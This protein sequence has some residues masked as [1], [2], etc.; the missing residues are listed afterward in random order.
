MLD[1]Q[2]K[3]SLQVICDLREIQADINNDEKLQTLWQEVSPRLVGKVLE[4]GKPLAISVSQGK[5]SLWSLDAQK[6]PPIAEN[7]AIE[8]VDVLR[9]PTLLYRCQICG[10]Y[11]PLRCATCVEQGKPEGQERLCTNCARFIKDRL[12]AYCPTHQLTC[13]C[14]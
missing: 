9:R 3:I 2:E 11:G 7:T 1:V 5:L 10:A 4:Y 8:I 6:T 12:T 14:S 13:Q